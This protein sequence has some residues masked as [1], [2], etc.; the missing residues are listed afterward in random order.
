MKEEVKVLKYDKV[1]LVGAAKEEAF[2]SAP[3]F[4]QG[5]ATQAY[6]NWE[7]KQEGSVTEAMKNDFYMDYLKKKSKFAPG[8]GFAIVLQSAVEDTRVRP[9]SIEDVKNEK[10]KRKYKTTYEII[11]DTTGEILGT[12]QETKA[13]AKEI[14]KDL[15]K[16]G[17]KHNTTCRYTHQVVE[18]EPI[19]FKAK[20]AP[21]K[22]T[23]QGKY[24]AFGVRA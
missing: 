4:V 22:A 21:S 10:G 8:T 5:D 24:I 17:L 15:Y 14:A 20:Y 2:K 6:K 23:R 19:A 12:T 13:K 16:K 9:Y 1:E 18:G 7:S 3:F 11:D